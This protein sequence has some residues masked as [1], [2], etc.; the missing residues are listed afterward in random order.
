LTKITLW[1]DLGERMRCFWR[2]HWL[3]RLPRE[4]KLIP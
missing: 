4:I 1:S 2:Q 3:A